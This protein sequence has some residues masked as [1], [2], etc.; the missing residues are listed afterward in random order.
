MNDEDTTPAGTPRPPRAKPIQPDRPGR[1]GKA[2]SDR[3]KTAHDPKE[4]A[5]Q[6][7]EQ[8]RTALENVRDG[9]RP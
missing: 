3:P 1:A 2:T 4:A 9:Y 7:H 8:S 6:Q 5:E